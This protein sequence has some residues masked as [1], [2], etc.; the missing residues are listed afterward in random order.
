[1]MSQLELLQSFVDDLLSLSLIKTGLFKL[2][3]QL[4]DIVEVV[5]QVLKIFEPSANSKDIKILAFVQG[6]NVTKYTNGEK[7]QKGLIPKLLGDS[8]RVRQILI[9]LMK[10]SLKFTEK[11]LITVSAFYAHPKLVIVV[12]DTGAGISH[13]DI[14]H[15]FTRFGKL[16]R[17]ANQNDAGLGLGLK[18]VKS[19]VELHN[20]EV[21]VKSDGPGQGSS[22]YVKLS[23]NHFDDDLI[24]STTYEQVR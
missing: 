18:I 17:T 8:R 7:F 22:F 23:I 15:V 2:E 13:E 24:G 19:I 20:G 21:S 12:K 1:M 4:F 6:K 9:N 11:G 16:K 5:Q 10:N 14:P 3:I